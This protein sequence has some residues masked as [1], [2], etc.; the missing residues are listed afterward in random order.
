[1]R[2]E[3]EIRSLGKVLIA[4]YLNGKATFADIAKVI[5]A[6]RP[7]EAALLAIEVAGWL[8]DLYEQ[9]LRQALIREVNSQ[10]A[11]NLLEV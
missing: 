10:C 11:G 8:P 4:R 1:M 9:Q 6:R 3:R 5:A 7:A 2:L